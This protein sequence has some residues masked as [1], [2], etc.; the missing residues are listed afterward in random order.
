MNKRWSLLG[1]AVLVLACGAAAWQT[2]WKAH[3]RNRPAPKVIDP[4]TW[5]SQEA[6]GKAPSD[7][8]VLFDGKRS[9]I[10]FLAKGLDF[11]GPELS[12]LP[13]FEPIPSGNPRNKTSSP[14]YKSFF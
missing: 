3:D 7:A 4:G 8:T 14:I 6:A 5:S 10:P 13:L 2:Q 11:E 9:T 12:K 1:A